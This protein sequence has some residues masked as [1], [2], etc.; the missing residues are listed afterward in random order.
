MP[1]K[2]RRLYHA[3]S[4][5]LYPFG[6]SDRLRLVHLTPAFPPFFHFALSFYDGIR[7]AQ[8]ALSYF[9]MIDAQT[10]SSHAKPPVDAPYDVV[11]VRMS[12]V[13]WIPVVFSTRESSHFFGRT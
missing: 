11:P 12:A 4:F 5:F 2:S 7:I 3:D 13:D 1:P 8:F 9:L 10:L 6:C